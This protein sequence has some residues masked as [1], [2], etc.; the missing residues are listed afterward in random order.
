M[1]GIQI[2]T[3][4]LWTKSRAYV[5]DVLH[6]VFQIGK[7]ETRSLT[8]R[9]IWL[10]FDPME[11]SIIECDPTDNAAEASHMPFLVQCMHDILKK[12]RL[13]KLISP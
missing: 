13:N 1:L 10:L 12:I 5:G 7:M 3:E 8:L 4:S 11:Y 2:S 9:A 6:L